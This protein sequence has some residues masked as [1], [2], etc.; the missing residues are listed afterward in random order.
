M[1]TRPHRIRKPSGRGPTL[2]RLAVG[3]AVLAV[4][5]C[6]SF[7]G[8]LIGSLVPGAEESVEN[9]QRDGAGILDEPEEGPF[10]SVYLVGPVPG[11]ER[12]GFTGRPFQLPPALFDVDLFAG[13]CPGLYLALD[14]GPARGP[15]AV[16]TGPRV[17]WIEFPPPSAE[18]R[19]YE[20]FGQ[21]SLGSGPRP[22]LDGVSYRA[23]ARPGGACTSVGASLLALGHAPWPHVLR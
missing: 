8:D 6:R 3:V 16:L 19:Y 21:V 13:A 22:L 4:A 11:W 15:V 9:V 7:L 18:D 10:R 12:W 14:P 20:R 23:S 17:G 5:G 1:T 2:R